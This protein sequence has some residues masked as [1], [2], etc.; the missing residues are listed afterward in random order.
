ML[1][2]VSVGV[3]DVDRS[4][5]FYDMIMAALGCKRV[6]EFLPHA[7][8][9]GETMPELWIGLPHDHQEP[10]VGNGTHIAFVAKNKRAVDA[11]HQAALAAGGSDDGPPGP[12]PE[13][14]PQY[15]GAFVRDPDGNKLEAMLLIG[16]EVV[17]AG[18]AGNRGSRG[19]GGAKRKPARRAAARK[20]AARPGK[21]GAQGAK[22]RKAPARGGRRG[23]RGKAR[24]R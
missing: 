17:P 4:A 14:T 16:Q 7:V 5:R 21:K 22:G 12:R 3:T 6:M 15:Y 18:S 1:H 19:R 10:S 2:H 13:Y 24:K 11:F 8:A 20:A 23:G 9:Y